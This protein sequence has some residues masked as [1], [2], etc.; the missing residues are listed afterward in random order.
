MLKVTLGK[1]GITVNKN[2]F[3]CLP[4]Q[5]VTKEEAAKLLLKAFDRGFQYFDTARDYTDSEEK[6]GYALHKIRPQLFIAT[7]THAKDAKKFWTDLETSLRLLQTDYIDVYQF[8]NPSFVPKPGEENG[9][10]EAALKAQQEG[11]IRFIGITNHR[12]PVALEAVASGLYAT[13]QY[14]FSYLANEEELALVA[15]TKEA[16]MG[17]IAMKGMAGG[18]LPDGR[19]SYAFMSKF[20]H[21]LPIWGIQR[22]RELEQ[23]LSCQDNPPVLD[24]AMQ[25]LIAK[26][27]KEL[28]GGF[29]RSCGYCLPCPV[30]IDIPQAARM[31]LLLRR[32]PTHLNLTPERQAN[33]A[34]IP[35]CLHCNHCKDNCPYGL[36]TPELLKANYADYL[37]FL[38]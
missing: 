18:L 22:D 21:V 19:V 29:C 32:F 26:N 3:G 5:R 14:P 1:T 38:K 30:G 34:L 15:R 36:D 28:V 33:M 23:F 11:K 17:F 12:M 37:T 25:A 2:G 20:D 31:S 9:L 7:K 8:H 13:M 27:K 6:M 10:Y 16:K 4:I 24:D 35:K